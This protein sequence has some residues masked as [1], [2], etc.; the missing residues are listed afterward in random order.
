MKKSISKLLL[1]FSLVALTVISCN[2]KSNA[3]TFPPGEGAFTVH[4]AGATTTTV[5]AAT[6]D[7][8][9]FKATI[10]GAGPVTI[11]NTFTGAT[12]SIAGTWTLFVSLD[13]V[14][15]FPF[16]GA[17][18]GGTA[19]DSVQVLAATALNS[20][21]PATVAGPVTNIFTWTKVWNIGKSNATLSTNGTSMS[22]NP[23]KYY[24]IRFISTSSTTVAL[25]GTARYKC[26]RLS[27]YQ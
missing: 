2:T 23:F 26:Q 1:L 17:N 5:A 22:G 14:I 10:T 9:Y 4:G 13:G 20:V 25:T 21:P 15:Y 18:T 16:P 11:T 24:M 7:T 19:L 12:G 8:L 6:L 27:G 3:Q